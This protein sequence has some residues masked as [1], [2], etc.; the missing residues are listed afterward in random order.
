[1]KN[2]FKILQAAILGL[3]LFSC[4]REEDK[5]I[6]NNISSS[7]LTSDVSNVVLI[8]ENATAKAI[9]FSWQ[10]PVYNP[11]LVTQNQIQIALKG[12]NFK[13]PKV[14]DIEQTQTSL[15]YT[16][17]ELNQ[18]LLSM[19]IPFS[20][21]QVEVRLK[22]FFPSAPTIEPLY[23]PILTLTVTPYA[24]ISYLYA[25]GAYQDW[26]PATAETLVSATS[27]GIY[28]GYI[29]FT[30]P[31]SEFKITTER[32]WDN[33]YGT[34]DNKNLVYNG[35]G[36]LKAAN[37]GYQK[38]TV[39]TNTLTFALEAYSWGVIGDATPGGWDVDTDLSWNSTNQTWEIANIAL[40]GG[41][42]LKF[43]LNDAW[44][45][46]YGGSNGSLVDGGDNIKVAESGNYK[47]VFDLINLKYTITKL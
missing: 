37:A 34:T 17:Q 36:N 16:V 28:I 5:A 47:I 4:V 42:E 21:T 12:T 38:L 43:R 32:N 6:F 29:K 3:I 25:P 7:T 24:L 30:A 13:N 22:S 35:G 46:N 14:V 1:M 33:S 23:S 27:N 10:K 39:N 20:A 40:V 18:L 31:D 2:I 41:K 9:T 11:N 19:D 45:V 15:S 26:A 44:S 8:K